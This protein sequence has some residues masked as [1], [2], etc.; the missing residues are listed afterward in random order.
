MGTGERMSR[1]KGRH[2]G[3]GYYRKSLGP[4]GKLESEVVK[5]CAWVSKPLRHSCVT[6]FEA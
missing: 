1:S 4:E 6:R 2:F 5:M 3:G